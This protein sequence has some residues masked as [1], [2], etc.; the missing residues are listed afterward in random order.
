M[1]RIMVSED[2]SIAAEYNQNRQLRW[3][4]LKKLAAGL[5][6]LSWISAP[7]YFVRDMKTR[8][9]VGFASEFDDGRYLVTSNAEAAGMITQPPNMEQHYFPWG[10]SVP[11]LLDAHRKRQ[12]EMLLE[13]QGVKSLVAWPVEDILQAHDRLSTQKC[14]YRAS[15]QWITQDEL[16]AMSNGNHAYADEV[17]AEIKKLLELEAAETASP[18]SRPDGAS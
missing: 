18:A 15:V 14:E 10:T 13:S 8:H 3:P 17:Y 5:L 2:G 6:G 12:Q 11:V 1:M 7:K 9:C 16:R 4:L